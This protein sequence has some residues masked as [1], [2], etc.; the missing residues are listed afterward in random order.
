MDSVEIVTRQAELEAYCR[1]WRRLGRFAFDTEFIRDETYESALCLIQVAADGQ[2]ALIDPT[3]PIDLASFWDLVT[4][5]KVITVVHAGKEDFEVCLRA[6]S[7]TP[8]NVFDVQ[9]A[10]GFLGYGY[11][12]S[13][14]RLMADVLGQRISKGQTLTDWLR[15]PLTDAQVRYAVEDVVHLPRVYGKLRSG[16]KERGR[17]SWAAEEFQRF[18][19]PACYEPPVRERLF[20][21]KGTKRLDGLGLAVL[22]RLIAWR[23]QWA[24]ERNRPLRAM[25]RDDV[26]VEIARRRP[27]RASDLEVMRGFPQARNPKIIRELLALIEDAGRVPKSEW[28]TPFKQPKE[29]P[30][31]RVMLDVLSAVTR[32]TCEEQGVSHDLVC[33]TQRLR[34]V[35]EY[36]AGLISE[37][38]ALL[39][40]WR[41]EFIGNRLLDLLDGHSELHVSGWPDHA[42]LEV[43]THKSKGGSAHARQPSPNRA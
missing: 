17:L 43:A 24:E 37:R 31:S 36:R 2:V 23:D 25:M 14:T 35:L 27:R 20:R 42:R 32:A 34:E 7:Q 15:R 33:T 11:P 21:L 28:P 18:E 5:P 13:L 19:D 41:E 39:R 8:R 29:A 30:M 3:A 26:L 40:G 12:L 9:I 4:D 6:T 1:S 16:L 22:E 10:A 38:P